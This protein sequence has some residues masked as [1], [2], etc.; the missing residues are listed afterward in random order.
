MTDN[1]AIAYE[2]D[3]L[4]MGLTTGA[5]HTQTN[6]FCLMGLSDLEHAIINPQ[7]LTQYQPD[8][9]KKLRQAKSLCAWFLPSDIGTSK[10]KSAVENHN[11]YTCLVA[12][13]D[14]GNSPLEE[15]KSVLKQIGI[16]SYYIYST[17]SSKPED[18][19]WRVVVPISEAIDLDHWQTLQTGLTV[20]LDGDDCAKRSQQ[21]SYLPALSFYNK[22]C[23]Q[24]AIEKGEPIDVFNSQFVDG[25]KALVL[26]QENEIAEQEKKTKLSPPKFVSQTGVSPIDHFNNSI[27]WDEL[28]ANKGFKRK[29]K[30]WLHPDSTSGAPGVFISYRDDSNGRYVS[31]HTSDP[32]CD[33]FSHDKFD[34]YCQFEYGSISQETIIKAATA[35]ARETRTIDGDT[36]ERHNQRNYAKGSQELI[37]DKF[38][39]LPQ[40]WEKPTALEAELVKVQSFDPKLLPPQ[41]ENY[42]MDFSHRM[43]K[44]PADFAAISTIICAGALIGGSAEIQ[45]KRLDTGWRI[46]PTMWGGAV[47]QP[48]TK[49]TPS[50]S[51]GRR[52]LEHAQKSVIDKL[53]AEKMEMYELEKELYEDE[54]ESANE[55]AKEALK[56]GN[57]DEALKLK[58]QAKKEQPQPPKIRKAVINDSTSE[59]LAIRLEQNPLGVLMFRDELSS[60]LANME[61]ADR[62]HERG[63]YLEGFNGFGGY[64]QERVTRRNVELDRVIISIMG[65]IQ[66]AKLTPLLAGKVNG[67]GDDGLLERLMQMLVYPDFSEM[68]YVDKA[69]NI[70]AETAAKSTYEAL[71]YLGEYDEPLVCKFD[72]DAQD[73]WEKW[74]KNMIKREKSATS[75]WQSMLGKYPA[76]CAKLALVFHLI[77]ECGATLSGEEPEPSDTIAIEHLKRAIAWME[78][79]ES[80]ANRIMTYFN[81]E[82]EIAPAKVLL[83]KLPQLSPFFTKHLVSQKDWKGLTTKELRENA[84]DRLKQS[85]YIKEIVK[86]NDKGRD[87]VQYHVHPDY[88]S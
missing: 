26:Q 50:L 6:G 10:Q 11:N 16:N 84:I 62:Q 76:L 9:N 69:P 30:K 31:S 85:G 28:L 19:R 67:H 8:T 44:A 87:T 80:H 1:S 32:L 58:R 56:D 52:L 64:S 75:Q 63:F 83:S 27:T 29:G 35:Y 43:D 5:N 72:N 25:A 42:V 20:A 66:P 79:L 55:K 78:Y 61:R 33:G 24:Y 37:A 53:N 3:H 41:L 18:M 21:I 77:G 51:C 38:E 48:S 15:V 45:P 49:K 14:D 36:L 7:D 22:D 88:Q 12:D 70:L 73:L 2:F 4:D 59:A 86:R 57:K 23:Y 68:E 34:V 17:M 60:W 71:A 65:G 82:Q 13:I 46:V 54:L 81:A 39:D 74:A 47:G 40:Q